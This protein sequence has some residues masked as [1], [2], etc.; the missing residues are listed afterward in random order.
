MHGTDPRTTRTDLTWL[1]TIGTIDE[2]VG[3]RMYVIS[4]PKGTRAV[5]HFDG[6]KQLVVMVTRQGILLSPDCH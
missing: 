6:T 5:C 3:N 1:A 4:T 2:Q